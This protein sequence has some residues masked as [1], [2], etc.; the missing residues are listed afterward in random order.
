[1]QSD[2][3]PYKKF[4]HT[5]KYQEWACTE[6]IPRPSTSLGNPSEEIKPADPLTLDFYSP[7]LRKY[8]SVV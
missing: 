3:G 1:M 2:G 4:G 8:I 7:Q 5:E 6:E